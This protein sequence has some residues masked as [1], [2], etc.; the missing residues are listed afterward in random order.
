MPE[1]NLI[2][3]ALVKSPHKV[4]ARL[5]SLDVLRATTIPLYLDPSPAKQTL[6]QWFD[7]AKVP[8]FKSNPVAKRGGG[9]TYYS[10]AHVENF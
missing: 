1:E 10:V 4:T 7:D 9:P 2:S 5:A 6:R 3:T 8:R